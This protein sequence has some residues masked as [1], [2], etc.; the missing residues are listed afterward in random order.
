MSFFDYTRP[1]PPQVSQD[2]HPGQWRLIEAA[3]DYPLTVDEVKEHCRVT[4]SN[5]DDTFARLIRV[6]TTYAEGVTQ[7][8]FESQTWDAVFSRFPCSLLGALILPKPPLVSVVQ[9]TYLD[10]SENEQLVDPATYR[11]L[12]GASDRPAR[13]VIKSGLAWP[14]TGCFKDAVRV[15]FVA[16][17]GRTSGSPQEP[18]TPEDIRHAMLIT[19]NELYENRIDTVLGLNVSHIKAIDALLLP[20]RVDIL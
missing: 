18:L 1:N 7:R 16:G 5:D 8:A 15:R 13:V 6:A 10:A 17:Y 20:C 11:V 4:H 2:E 19:I 3:T 9:I 14:V 12:Y